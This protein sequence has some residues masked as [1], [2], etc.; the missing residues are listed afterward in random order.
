MALVPATLTINFTSNYAGQHRVCYRL[1]GIGAY[2]CTTLVTCTGGGALCSAV[3][4]IMVDNETCDP[5]EYDGYVQ[6]SCEDIGSL[7]GRVPFVITFTPNPSC[8]GYTISCESVSVLDYTVGVNGSG[9]NPA[10]P[11][12][13]TVAPGPGIGS[14]ATAV[15]SDNGILTATTTNAGAGYVDG[16][17]TLV[18][19]QTI[20]GIGS[21]AL[22]TVVVFG[23]IITA[24]T[25]A[26]PTDGGS[27]YAINDTY[28]FNAA[29]LGGAGGGCLF[30]VLTLDYGRVIDVVLFAGGS[31]YIA[32][33]AVT[34]AAP[35]AGVTATATAILNTCASYNAGNNC[36]ATPKANITLALGDSTIVCAP[37]I[38]PPPESPTSGITIVQDACCYDCTSYTVE[39]AEGD[40][41]RVIYTD[42]ATR[43]QVKT[44]LTGPFSSTVCMVTGSLLVQ[45]ISGAPAVV[46]TGAA[47]P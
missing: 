32:T 42:C 3:I 43:N 25:P 41:S 7:V 35:G 16:T 14:T 17:Y 33:P 38:P 24:A 18:P 29:N 28:D 13:V 22:F 23:G 34:I 27:D 8:K 46:T 47:C 15:V 10:I 40:Q 1:N 9:Y 20:T 45:Y 6:A 37:V 39:L 31:G 11:P 4:N 26:V 2:D 44:V 36:D 21:G 5:V 30:T 19:A 12:I